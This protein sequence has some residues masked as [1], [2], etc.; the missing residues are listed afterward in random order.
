M[1]IANTISIEELCGLVD[2]KIVTP[3]EARCMVNSFIPNV[4]DLQEFLNS[5]H[6]RQDFIKELIA[7]K[8]EKTPLV[9]IK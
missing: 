6:K 4:S 5:E 1:K 2:R 8:E 9:S 3:L 7:S